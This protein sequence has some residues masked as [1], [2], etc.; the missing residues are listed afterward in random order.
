MPRTSNG[1]ATPNVA[2]P[3]V[4]PYFKRL[5]PVEAEFTNDDG[6]PLGIV[7][8]FDDR[9]V[10]GVVHVQFVSQF[11]DGKTGEVKFGKVAT[12]RADDLA[13]LGEIAEFLNENVG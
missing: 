3:K 2:T 5:T 10:T 11:T 8:V 1:V 6:G 7:R 9:E 12:F 13:R 4:E